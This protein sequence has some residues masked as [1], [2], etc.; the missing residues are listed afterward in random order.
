MA[1]THGN[2]FRV[3]QFVECTPVLSTTVQSLSTR[4][5][6]HGYFAYIKI[7][8][9]SSAK[10]EK[11]K[12]SSQCLMIMYKWCLFCFFRI[13]ATGNFQIAHLFS[14]YFFFKP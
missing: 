13:R 3:L 10:S 14:L 1:F 2:I 9:I 5:G 11:L 8:M 6:A 12:S 7:H 4:G